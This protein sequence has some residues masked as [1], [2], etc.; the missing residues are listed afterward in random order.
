MHLQ[1]A[2]LELSH[3]NPKV[4]V[5]RCRRRWNA[6]KARSIRFYKGSKS[7]CSSCSRC[8]GGMTAK[9][10]SSWQQA[11]TRSPWQSQRGGGQRG[12]DDNS[13][14]TNPG[15]GLFVAFG[16]HPTSCF[17]SIRMRIILLF[18]VKAPLITHLAAHRL[19]ASPE[20]S[21]PIR[22]NTLRHRHGIYILLS[23]F[24]DAGNSH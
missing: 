7:G 3:P 6:V 21:L 15:T 22:P 17:G 10:N 19:I 16:G 20:L 13:E 11:K 1:A 5:M 9:L 18:P 23:R 4:V 8:S 2:Q 24:A 14:F 12:C